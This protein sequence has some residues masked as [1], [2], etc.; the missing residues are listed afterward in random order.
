MPKAGEI[1]GDKFL[2]TR[3]GF[4]FDDEIRRECQA[5]LYASKSELLALDVLRA[6]REQGNGHPLTEREKLLLET[7][8]PLTQRF[9]QS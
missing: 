2:C 4:V 3:C 8:D 6:R 7:F 9:K 1:A 5:P